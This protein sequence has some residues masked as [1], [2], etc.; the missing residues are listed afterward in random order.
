MVTVKQE[1]DD[2]EV[3]VID[4]VVNGIESLKQL[5]IKMQDSLASENFVDYSKYHEEYESLGGYAIESQAGKLLSGLG[6]SVSQLQQKVKELS[7]GWQIRLNLAQALLQ[8]S[9]ILL[10]D[11]PTNHL[12]LDAVLWLEEY[13]QE[14]KGSL[15]LISHDRIFLDNVVKQIFYID[16]KNIDTYTGNYSSYEKQSYEQ[17]VL[18][19]KQFEKQQKHIAHLESF[20]NR[21]KAKASKAKQAQSRVKMLEKIQRIEAVK[22]D[23]EFSFEFKQVKEHLGGT[24]VSLQNADLGYGTKKILNNVKLNIYNE[25]RIGLLGLNG[26]GK[27]TLIKSLIGDID[28]LSGKIEKHPNLKVG[29][30]SQ[31][32]LDMLDLQASPLLHMQRLDS[33]VTQ[34]KKL[35]TFLGSFNFVGDKALAK[36][37]TF[38]GG[39]KARLVLAI[40]VYQQPNFLLL[41]EPTNHLDIGVRE[42]LTVALQSFQGAIILVSHDRFLLESTVDEYMLVGEGQVKPFDGDMKGY[43]KY[44]LEVKKTQNNT[45]NIAGQ[46]NED[47]KKQNRRLSADKRKQL[48]PLQDKIKKLERAL[49]KLQ[50]QDLQMQD[51][52][53]DQSLYDDK[54]KLQQTLL[55]HSNL[56]GKIEEI[57]LDWFVALEELESINQN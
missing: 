33:Q 3:K 22:S 13:L 26:A 55:E 21:F 6:F 32:S 7:G 30:F 38:S 37:G 40:I 15:L 12:D 14:Y 27:S 9:D 4:Y 31:H 18:Q 17:K 35:R 25:M 52:L 45:S 34:E 5:K 51:A 47:S 39:E 50:Q 29:Y 57:E 54:E 48:K 20:V 36:A 42:A 10:L 24:L 53:Q 28:I 43:Y 16:N 11:E 44:I 8:E 41:D 56:K 46:I 1:V 19:Q 49:E 23:S 2:F